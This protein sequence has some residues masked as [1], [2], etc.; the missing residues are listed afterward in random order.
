MA[1]KN[2]GEAAG[3]ALEQYLGGEGQQQAIIPACRIKFE[4]M[5]WD[6]LEDVPELKDEMS[7]TVTGPVVA[8]TTRVMK[9]GEIRDV[10][11]VDVQSVERIT[12]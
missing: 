5:S 8:R 11:I 2:L 6:S 1:R 12:G 10:A 4:G 9:D 3:D 7:F